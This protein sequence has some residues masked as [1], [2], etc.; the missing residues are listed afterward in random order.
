M[1]QRG[2][3]WLLQACHEE[4]FLLGC[5]ETRIREARLLASWNSVATRLKTPVLR[6]KSNTTHCGWE[7]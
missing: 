6:P 4:M 1:A 3:D 7:I 5:C 2:I